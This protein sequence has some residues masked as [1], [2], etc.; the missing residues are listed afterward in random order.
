MYHCVEDIPALCDAYEGLEKRA[1]EMA[2]RIIDAH[3]DVGRHYFK[4]EGILFL[5]GLGEEE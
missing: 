5:L 3:P 1:R 2:Q 4:N